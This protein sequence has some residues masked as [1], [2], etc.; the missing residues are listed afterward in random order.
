M[1]HSAG[2][3]CRKSELCLTSVK[4]SALVSALAV[5]PVLLEGAQQHTYFLGASLSSESAYYTP[6]R[7]VPKHE[8]EKH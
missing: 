1:K 2:M 4:W 5:G 6:L 8:Y 7:F 3:V